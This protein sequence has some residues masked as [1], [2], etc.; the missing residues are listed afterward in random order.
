MNI[1][2]FFAL[3]FLAAT[4]FNCGIPKAEADALKEEIAELKIQI[5]DCQN[6][7]DRLLGKANLFFEQN[8]YLKSQHVLGSLISKFPHSSQANIGKQLLKKVNIG[9]DKERILKE[10]EEAE[11]LNRLANATKRMRKKYDDIDE[12]T[13]YRDKTSPY[14]TNY[15]GF[16]AYIGKP[17]NGIPYLRLRIQYAADDWLFIERYIIKVDGKTY[18]ILEENYGEIETDNGNGGIWEWLDRNVGDS[19]LNIIKAVA[20]GKDVKIRYVGRKYHKDKTITSSQKRALKNVLDAYEAL[21]G[22]K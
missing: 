8:D 14:Y 4:F 6:G 20:N 5:D 21:G 1:Q 11:R 18:N 7:A 19:E 17:D 13:W 3:S 16:F 2:K 9:L 12:I 10:K 15:N 22:S